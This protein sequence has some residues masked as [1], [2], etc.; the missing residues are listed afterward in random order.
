MT[1]IIATSAAL[2]AALVT[3]LVARK[4]ARGDSRRAALAR[5]AASALAVAALTWAVVTLSLAICVSNTPLTDDVGNVYGSVAGGYR[6]SKN[7]PE[8]DDV[9]GAVLIYYKP[10]CAD[11]AAIWD[12][13]TDALVEAD[14][15][16][17][18]LINTRSPTGREL[19]AKYPVRE[20][21]AGVYVAR[22]DNNTESF[23][24][25]LFTTTEGGTVFRWEA[26][27]FLLRCQAQGW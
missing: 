4:L 16:D 26:L 25:N 13:L 9:R 3:R 10:G 24:A 12:A 23:R 1:V 15:P 17:V 2:A 8:G 19:L 20:V 22:A 6:E 27:N 14:R 21:P 11:C 18:Y 5:G 7:V